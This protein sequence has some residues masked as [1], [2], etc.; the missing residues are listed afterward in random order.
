M[1]WTYVTIMVVADEA[2]NAF[3]NS[4]AALDESSC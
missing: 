3:D 1:T 4:F 2:F